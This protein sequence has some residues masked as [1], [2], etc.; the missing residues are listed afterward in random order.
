MSRGETFVLGV[1]GGATGTRAMLVDGAGQPR[2]W[3]VGGPANPKAVGEAAAAEAVLGTARAALAGARVTPGHTPLTTFLGLAGLDSSGDRPFFERIAER[4]APGGAG[5]DNDAWVAFAAAHLGGDGV[6]LIAG[7][8]SIAAGQA[9][10]RRVRVGGYGSRFGDEGSGFDLGRRAVRAAL[11]EMD[12]RGPR[13]EL[14]A[15]V[16]AH[17]SASSADRLLT[18]LHNPPVTPGQVAGL[19]PAVLEAART[20][21]AVAGRI[22]EKAASEAA[23]LAAACAQRLGD[24]AL[25][26]AGSGGLFRNAL[27]TAAFTRALHERLPGAPVSVSPNPPVVGAVFLAWTAAGLDATR[28]PADRLAR[29]AKAGGR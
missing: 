23:E 28:F 19:A 22:V 18:I 3:A 2:G 4:L 9:Q 10:G 20:G 27:W 21:D 11:R 5:L 14:T 13:T 8:G 25:P 17:F 24:D 16:L 26:V 7:T 29:A 6:V 15:A 1:D 12:G